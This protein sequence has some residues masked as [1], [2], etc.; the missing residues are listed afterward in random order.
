MS[1]EL[2]PTMTIKL[3][4]TKALAVSADGKWLAVAD[5]EVVHV[6]DGKSG[7]PIAKLDGHEIVDGVHFSPDG[8]TLIPTDFEGE[9]R[10]YDTKTWKTR[11]VLGKKCTAVAFSRDSKT[12]AVGM[13]KA[14]SI[15]DVASG[16]ELLKIDP[17]GKV[18]IDKID[19]MGIVRSDSFQRTHH[20]RIIKRILPTS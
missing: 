2:K 1:R 19:N 8:T 15:V 6:L 17:A 9:S 5:F 14:V 20:L 10:I 16:K 12:V 3:P 4:E 13:K 18:R 11:H 7:K